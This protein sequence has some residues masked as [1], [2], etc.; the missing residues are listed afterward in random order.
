MIQLLAS[1]KHLEKNENNKVLITDNEKI[2][3]YNKY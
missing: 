1:M 2:Y 3:Y